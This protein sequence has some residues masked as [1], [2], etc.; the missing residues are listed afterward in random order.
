MKIRSIIID[1]EPLAQRVIEK[2]AQDIPF[3]EIAGKCNQAVEAIEILHQKQIDLLFL[4]I[5]MPKLSGIDFLKTMKHPPLV[6]ITTAYAEFALEGYELDVVDYLMKPFAF[7]RFVK[8]VHKAQDILSSKLTTEEQ[9]GTS[10]HI[11]EEQFIFVK[12]E[13][14]TFKVNL[15]D[16]MYVEALG[17]YVKIYTHER[18]IVS[19]QSLKNVETILP[20]NR[21]PR[22]HK[23]YVISLSKVELIEGNQ[24]RIGEKFIPIGSNYKMEFEKLV[25]SA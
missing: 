20:P 3:L 19:Y 1:D 13:K 8:A 18:M 9:P 5:N 21:F 24:V 2:Y 14:K 25:R 4:D 16:L 17:D 10:D 11:Q 15:N 7:D 12:S 6:I 23:S 22:V